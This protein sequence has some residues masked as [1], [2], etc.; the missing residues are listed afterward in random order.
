[1]LINL[2][3]MGTYETALGESANYEADRLAE[4]MK[5]PDTVWDYFD[6]SEFLNIAARECVDVFN[7]Y[8]SELYRGDPAMK[9]DSVTSPREYNF[10]TDRVFA[11]ISASWACGMLAV[12]SYNKHAELNRVILERFTSR[13]GFIS[14][15]SNDIKSWLA[16]PVTEWDS[17][18]LGTLFIAFLSI[19]A[20]DWQEV[21]DARLIERVAESNIQSAFDVPL[22]E[23]Q[24][25]AF[26]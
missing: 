11:Q 1:M 25:A 20:P 5:N 24:E 7:E 26:D 17:N 10:E 15:Y 12:S 9:F 19:K 8:V 21:T 23:F 4:T 6:S 22:S 13:S 18:E 16:R 14:N 3:F 2:P